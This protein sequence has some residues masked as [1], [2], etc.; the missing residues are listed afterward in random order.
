[1]ASDDVVTRIRA[2]LDEAYEEAALLALAH[3][4]ATGI[5]LKTLCKK[6]CDGTPYSWQALDS[7]CRRMQR[8]AREGA[9]S[10]AA[11]TAAASIRH[12]RKVARDPDQ[13]REFVGSLDDEEKVDLGLDVLGL[14]DTPENR[15]EVRKTAAKG[16]PTTRHQPRG[17]PPKKADVDGLIG[18]AQSAYSKGNFLI[19][20]IMEELEDRPPAAGEER[21]RRL[22]AIDGTAEIAAIG[23]RMVAALRD[24]VETGTVDE[25][26]E[27]LLASVEETRS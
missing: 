11:R 20:R 18:D 6:V 14:L 23:P 27:E 25:D 26:L 12:A 7:R 1:M 24:Y 13:R 21:V 2:V 22:A 16:A 5:P 8:K 3:V 17:V 9:E 19:W 15:E 4:E 10:T